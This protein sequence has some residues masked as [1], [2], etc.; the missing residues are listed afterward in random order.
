[1]HAFPFM[2]GETELWEKSE[3]D[4]SHR[5]SLQLSRDR[6]GATHAA[7]CAG[8]RHTAPC[9]PHRKSAYITAA[10]TPL[11]AASSAPIPPATSHPVSKQAMAAWEINTPGNG[12]IVLCPGSHKCLHWK[13]VHLVGN[14]F[15]V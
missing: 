7:L 11:A 14:R 1:M 3:K 4:P 6:P 10:G 2:D 12:L 8:P 5:V 15:P 9:G 13:L